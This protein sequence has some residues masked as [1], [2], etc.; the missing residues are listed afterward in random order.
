[1]SKGLVDKLVVAISSRALFDLS[2]SHQVFLAQGVK[3]TGSTRSTMRMSCWSR[4]MR[5]RWCRNCWV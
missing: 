3:P 2:E 5:S 4:A 1:M